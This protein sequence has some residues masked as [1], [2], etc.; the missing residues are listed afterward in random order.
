[1][2]RV[3]EY[4]NA[5]QYQGAHTSKRRDVF[6]VLEPDSLQPT[7]RVVDT[8][9]VYVPLTVRFP[10]EAVFQEGLDKF[11]RGIGWRK[12]MKW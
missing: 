1:V 6:V 5:F 11:L 9:R 12:Q 4:P 8:N 3:F 2:D 10:K 7:L